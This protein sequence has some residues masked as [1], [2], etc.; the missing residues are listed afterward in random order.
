MSVGDWAS[1]VWTA[2]KGR[3]TGEDLEYEPVASDPEPVTQR[4]GAP[5]ANSRPVC[6]RCA[7]HTLVVEA[8]RW[9]C[10]GCGVSLPR[11]EE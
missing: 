10:P 7:Q 6:Q 1:N 3:D 5:G 8:D 4:G 2:V 11:T 9:A